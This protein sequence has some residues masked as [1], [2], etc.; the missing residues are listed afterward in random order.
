MNI[1]I[2]KFYWFEITAIIITFVFGLFVVAIMINAA[3]TNNSKSYE[4]CVR[5]TRNID[6]CEK[7]V[8]PERYKERLNQEDYF[9]KHVPALE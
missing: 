8:Y 9:H 7:E 2:I 6:G 1:K 3:P 4:F 5:A